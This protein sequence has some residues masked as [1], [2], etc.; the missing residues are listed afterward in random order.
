MT[1]GQFFVSGALISVYAPL[2]LF[3]IREYNTA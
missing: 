3:A 1:V 2:S